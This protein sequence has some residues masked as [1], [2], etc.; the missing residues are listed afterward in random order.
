MSLRVSIA[1]LKLYDILKLFR[2]SDSE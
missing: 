2:G 1:E